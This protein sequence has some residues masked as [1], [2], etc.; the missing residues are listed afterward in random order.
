VAVENTLHAVLVRHGITALR[1]TVGVIFLGFGLLKVLSWCQPGR[2][3]GDHD[4]RPVDVRA[5]ARGCSSIGSA[6]PLIGRP[7]CEM[8]LYTFFTKDRRVSCALLFHKSVF[9]CVRGLQTTGTD[10]D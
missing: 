9:L 3:P 10:S 7:D 1:V 8:R 4:G 2:E 6:E 5:R